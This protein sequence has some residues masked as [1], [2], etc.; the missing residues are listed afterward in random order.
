MGN[1]IKQLEL[2]QV[3]R[4]VHNQNETKMGNRSFATNPRDDGVLGVDYN[5]GGGVAREVRVSNHEKIGAIVGRV[6][7][8]DQFVDG[9][10]A[11][12]VG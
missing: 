5:G 8:E 3:K 6:G 1:L 7:P 11:A 10:V 9:E 4:S 12:A 2:K